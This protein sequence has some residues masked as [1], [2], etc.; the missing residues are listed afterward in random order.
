[1]RIIEKNEEVGT[2]RKG[3]S[4]RRIGD[5]GPDRETR[6]ILEGVDE[7]A[8]YHAASPVVLASRGASPKVARKTDR[9]C[10]EGGIWA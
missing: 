2:E 10:G 3:Q 1:M 4:S 6:G 9:R 8:R 7:P 5:V